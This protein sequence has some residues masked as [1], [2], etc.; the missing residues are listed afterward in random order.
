[1]RTLSE[2]YAKYATWFMIQSVRIGQMDILSKMNLEAHKGRPLTPENKKLTLW[3]PS[4]KFIHCCIESQGCRFNRNSGACIMCDYGIG[5]N[6][7]PDELKQALEQDLQPFTASVSTVLFGS[8]GSIFDTEEVSAECFDVLLDFIARQGIRT[9]IFETHCCTV[10]ESVLAKIKEKL[11]DYGKTVVIEMGYESCEP[12]IL[13]NCLNKVLDLNQLCHAMGMIHQYSMEVSLNVFLG[14]PFLSGKEQ[15]DTTVQS[16]EWAFENGAD[17]VVVFPC[18]IKPFTL[19]YQLYKNNL[20]EPISQWMLVELLS[21]IPEEK[22]DRITL[23]W[24]GDR[25]NF[26][27]NNQFPL[28]PPMDCEKCHNDILAFYRFFMKE[29]LC[30]RRKQLIEDFIHREMNCDCRNRFLESLKVQKK[31]LDAEE[32]E[33]LL[34]AMGYKK[35]RGYVE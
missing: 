15:L 17:S 14:A 7:T 10:N 34:K 6:L 3:R 26:Y 33:P 35:D 20:Y 5:R 16:V 13:K 11:C 30:T 18:N 2:Q 25:G 21:R 22:L 4:E 9:V 24:Y 28:I 23:S 19:L 32:I 8:Y 12:Y 1:M 29:P 31:R 27:E